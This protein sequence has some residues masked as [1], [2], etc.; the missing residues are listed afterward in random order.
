[1]T[2]IQSPARPRLVRFPEAGP[3]TL[4]SVALDAHWRYI[5]V[6]AAAEKDLGKTAAEL[7]GRVIWDVWPGLRESPI[8]LS[9]LNVM[10]TRESYIA[11]QGNFI[12]PD[13][14]I[15][16]DITPVSGGGIR[17]LYR[18]VPRAQKARGKKRA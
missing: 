5:R 17:V 12:Y 1:M 2:D 18:V 13:K 6:N 9:M 10:E 3:S 14:D 8:G 16:T 11:R 7:V 15:V 4:P